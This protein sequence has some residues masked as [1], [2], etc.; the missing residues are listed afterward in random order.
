[1]QLLQVPEDGRIFICGRGLMLAPVVVIARV[2][3]AKLATKS[4]DTIGMIVVL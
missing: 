4:G 3:E 1:M 2:K